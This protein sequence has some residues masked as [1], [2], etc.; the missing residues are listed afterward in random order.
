MAKATSKT[1][2]ASV[3]KPAPAKPKAKATSSDPLQKVSEDTLKI[4]QSLGIDRQLQ[5]DL[6]WCLGS[7]SHDKNPIGLREMIERSQVVLKVEQKKKTKGVTAK[8]IGDLEKV[9]KS[10]K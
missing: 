7:Y 8:L 6:K 9:L 5:A 2:S 3:K 1:S 4:L 10:V